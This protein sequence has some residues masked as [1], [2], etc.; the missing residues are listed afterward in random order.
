MKIKL[1]NTFSFL[2]AFLLLGNIYAQKFDKKYTE[3]FTVNKDVQLDINASNSIINVTTWNKNEVSVTAT[4]EVE[5]ISKEKAEEYFKKWNFEALGNKKKVSVVSSS[6]K[7]MGLNNIVFFE[8]MDFDINIP[9]INIADINIPEIEDIEIPEM[10]FD[11]DFDFDSLEDIEKKMIKENKYTFEYHNDNEHIIIKSKK[12]WDEFKKTKR[13]KEIEEELNNSGKRIRAEL[14]NSKNHLKNIDKQKLKE[15]LNDAKLQIKNI[16]KEQIK[17]GLLKAQ[18][19]LKNMN[20]NFNFN[21][22]EKEIKGKNVKIKKTIEIKVPKAA[23]FK[24]NTRHC[25]VDLPNSVA[26]GSLKYG[27]FNANNLIGGKLNIDSSPVNINSLNACTLF[28]NNV[29]DAKI[30]SVTNT[31]IFNNFS[32]L[33]IDKINKN[34]AV[35]DKFGE[36]TIKGFDVNFEEFVLDLSNSEAVLNFGNVHSKY[37]YQVNK[38]NL[39]NERVKYFKNDATTKNILK[40]N[41]QF[42]SITIK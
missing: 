5:G 23:T 31:N 32:K 6:G 9:E 40:V 21:A 19:S 42:S 8:N 3:T 15:A 39:Q 12:E 30:A 24:L 34:V 29:T 37:K 13:F 35:T 41:G 20:F 25:K 14:R 27:T 17:K 26:S 4:I 28:L 33:E 36:I 2:V 38:V 10:D 22:D 11:F 18:E 1:Y 7:S 16:D